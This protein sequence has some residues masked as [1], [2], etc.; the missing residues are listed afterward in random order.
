MAY[1]T[2]Q[3]GEEAYNAMLYSKTNIAG[4]FFDAVTRV[5]YTHDLE[6][7]THPVQT[8]AEITDHSYMHP[9]E[10]ELTV[11]MSD[12]M[13]SRFSGQF[14]GS[15]S[16]S[17]AGWDILKK[18]QEDRVPVSVLTR[19]G[20]YDNMLITSLTQTDSNSNDHT[21]LHAQVSLQE[22]L[23]AQ[24][25]YAKVSSQPAKSYYSMSGIISSEKFDYENISLLRQMAGG[26]L[27]NG[28]N[29]VPD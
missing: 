5:T 26:G 11:C 17:R 2:Q 15:W 1:G 6:V 14:T 12:V 24:I 21:A 29:Y 23:M 20:R 28:F 27:Y 10:L 19:L 22:V 7:T 25:S 9:K 3:S 4:Y 16:R 8:G 13:I 18:I